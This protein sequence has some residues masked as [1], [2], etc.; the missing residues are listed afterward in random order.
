MFGRSLV[1]QLVTISLT[2]AIKSTKAAFFFFPVPHVSSRPSTTAAAMLRR[3][4]RRSYA[5]ATELP[6]LQQPD[7]SSESE[8]NYVKEE[9]PFQTP[10]KQRRKAPKKNH[11]D[12]EVIPSTPSTPD[13]LCSSSLEGTSESIDTNLISCDKQFVDLDVPPAEFRPSASLTTGQ[14]FHWTALPTKDT[15]TRTTTAAELVASS[16]S[17]WGAHDATDWIGTL[18]ITERNESLVVHVRETPTTT[19][20]KI[21]YAPPGFQHTDAFLRDYFQLHV[22]LDKL[23]ES[24]AKDCPRLQKIAQCIPGVRMLRQDPW[25]TLITSNNNIP[26]IASIL[27]TLRREYG[28]RIPIPQG[29]STGDESAYSFPSLEELRGKVTEADLRR[30]GWGYRAKYVIQTVETL[31]NLGGEAYLSTLRN[32]KDPVAVQEALLQ[33]AGVGRKVADCVALFSLQQTRAIPVDVHVWNI[34]RR[35]YDPGQALATVK[36]LTPTI[37]KQVGDIFRDRF[38]EYAGWAHSLLF[39]AELPSFR[40]ILPYELIKEME[41]FKQVEQVRKQQ[42]KEAKAKTSLH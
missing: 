39:V 12:D 33:F 32:Q 1:V 13:L 28:R 3:S 9:S 41:E 20:Y 7:E 26:R 14:S 29:Y 4:P 36:S 35:D 19:L 18:R 30:L 42:L 22:S 24:W 27:A 10:K 2:T 38:G 34:A 40:P 6:R 25:E 8:T 5:A 21:L 23:Y 16:S 15:T 37:Y 31:H 17:A 11:E